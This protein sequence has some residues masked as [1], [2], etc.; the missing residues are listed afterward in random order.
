MGRAI[1]VNVA[2]PREDK[3]RNSDRR[4]GGKHY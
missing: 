1:T 4:G 3:P 2:K